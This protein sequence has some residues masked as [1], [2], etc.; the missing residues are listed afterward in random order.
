MEA[1]ARG[2]DSKLVQLSLNQSPTV[3]KQSILQDASH[4]S[5]V[6][7]WCTWQGRQGRGRS[8]ITPLTH[9][10]LCP[11]TARNSTATWDG[12]KSTRYLAI[13]GQA[14]TCFLLSFVILRF[15]NH[16]FISKINT[17]GDLLQPLCMRPQLGLGQVGVLF[18]ILGCIWIFLA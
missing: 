1:R 13:F 9:T 4:Q 15:T 7:S 2:S 8:S 14:G 3:S 11:L 5:T 18:V 16:K 6:V 17:K 12:Q 10:S